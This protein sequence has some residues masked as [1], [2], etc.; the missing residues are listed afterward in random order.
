VLFSILLQIVALLFPIPWSFITCGAGG[1]LIAVNNYSWRQ[2]A[3]DAARRAKRRDFSHIVAALH[4]FDEVF[5][6][7]PF[8]MG[9]YSLG[10]II[11]GISIQLGWASDVWFYALA[12][13]IVNLF[14][15]YRYNIV[16]NSA[17]ARAN[18]GRAVFTVERQIALPP[19]PRDP[20]ALVIDPN[21][22][23]AP[24]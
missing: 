8:L 20:P 15:I 22:S 14:K 3:K 11:V 21:L 7:W 9:I 24:A 2:I 23:P 19:A 12:M 4:D 18:L 16:G 10:G 6:A 5:R 17:W 13:V 1:I